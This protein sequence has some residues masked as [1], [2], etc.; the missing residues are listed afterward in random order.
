MILGHFAEPLA[1]CGLTGVPL[2]SRGGRFGEPLGAFW[3]PVGSLSGLLGV[4]V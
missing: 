1:A 3:E 4:S 2:G